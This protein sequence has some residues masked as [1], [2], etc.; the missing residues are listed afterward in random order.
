M[1]LRLTDSETWKGLWEEALKESA[2]HR[3]NADSQESIERW[4]GR[5]KQFA[6]N[7]VSSEARSRLQELL[8]WLEQNGALK[9]GFKVLDVGAGSGRYAIPMAKMGCEVTALEPAAAMVEQIRERMALENITNIKILNKPWQ[10]L[11]LESEKMLGQFDLV[12]ASMTPGIQGPDDILKMIRASR[13]ACYLSSHTRDRWHHLDK[14]W[15]DI[16]GQA[17]P[18]APGDFIYRFGYVYSLGYVPLTFHQKGAPVKNSKKSPE[19]IK[20]EILWLLSGH[21]G[22]AE[23]T[24]DKLARIDAYVNSIDSEKDSVSARTMSSQ[25]MLWFVNQ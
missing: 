5:A 12:F 20:E 23:M 14:V 21:I 11:D 9:K 1:S 22:Q 4:N 13:S 25:A 6:E 17:M 16:F 8:G 3:K 18:E 10:A 15:K 2:N 19:K 7:A 24:E